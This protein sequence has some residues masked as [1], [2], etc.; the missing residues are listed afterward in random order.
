MAKAAKQKHLLVAML[1]GADRGEYGKLVE[2]LRND[3]T[4]GGDYYP[5]NLTEAYELLLNYK[6]SQ[7]NLSARLMDDPEEVSFGNVGGDKGGIFNKDG[8]VS[9]G[10]RKKLWCYCCIGL[11]H[12]AR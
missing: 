4:K 3:F 2:E 5:A 1:C 11:S 10:R 12:I 6:T 8:R 7:S 9:R